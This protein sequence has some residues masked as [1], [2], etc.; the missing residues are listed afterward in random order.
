M[1][2]SKQERLLFNGTWPQELCRGSEPEIAER[3]DTSDKVQR[4]ALTLLPNLL[5]YFNDF[6]KH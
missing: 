2:H 4:Y 1:A 6:F 5:I 3:K